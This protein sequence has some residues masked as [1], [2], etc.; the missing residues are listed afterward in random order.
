MLL[1]DK[2]RRE[3]CAMYIWVKL[4]G[5]WL[6]CVSPA[7][8]R[9]MVSQFSACKQ[10]TVS[11]FFTDVFIIS[12]RQFT[13]F[14]LLLFLSLFTINVIK[15]VVIIILHDRDLVSIAKW[16]QEDKSII[17]WC[18]K[19]HGLDYIQYIWIIIYTLWLYS[20]KIKGQ[21]PLS[22]ECNT[23]A[24][25]NKCLGPTYSDIIW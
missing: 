11:L 13:W 2:T 8:R 7:L 1:F 12:Q 6:R 4:R 10:I 20:L 24:Y 14:I 3:K 25:A 15:A 21:C 16:L 5:D 18:T 22:Q 17:D 9:W 23:K 19:A